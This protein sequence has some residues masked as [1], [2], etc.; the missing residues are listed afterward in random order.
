MR[1]YTSV[2]AQ[3]VELRHTCY[4]VFGKRHNLVKL[5]QNTKNQKLGHRQNN[6]KIIPNP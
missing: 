4:R 1:C 5:G 6:P 2:K 3:Q